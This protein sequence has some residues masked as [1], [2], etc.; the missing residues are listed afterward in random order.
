MTKIITAGEVTLARKIV[1]EELRVLAE[2][3]GVSQMQMAEL[4][5]LHRSN[6]NRLLS[7]RYSP[8]L[9]NLLKITEALNLKLDLVSTTS[10]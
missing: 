8:S 3:R 1:L 4:T 7:G 6:V 10:R 5:G 2:S 9:D